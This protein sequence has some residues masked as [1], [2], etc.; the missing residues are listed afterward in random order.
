V[1]GG[2]S[3]SHNPTLQAREKR[4][5]EKKKKKNIRHGYSFIW[6]GWLLTTPFQL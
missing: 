1:C 5:A 4:Q 6:G 3:F 2:D